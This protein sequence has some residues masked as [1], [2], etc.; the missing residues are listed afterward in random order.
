MHALQRRWQASKSRIANHM[1]GRSSRSSVLGEP[2]SGAGPG[3]SSE[4]G[5]PF[6]SGGCASC[7]ASQTCRASVRAPDVA[8]N[9]GG[10]GLAGFSVA[11][12]GS[13]ARP[14]ETAVSVKRDRTDMVTETT[15]LC[16]QG[17]HRAGYGVRGRG[18]TGGGYWTRCNGAQSPH[19]YP[20]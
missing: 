17:S 3:R 9:M 10:G 5:L 14:G 12:E 20:A 8:L 2:E 13:R 1:C 11:S 6:G 7:N 16:G 18:D 15:Q 19:P 4:W